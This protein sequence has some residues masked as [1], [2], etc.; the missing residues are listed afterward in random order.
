MPNGLFCHGDPCPGD[1]RAPCQAQ[2]APPTVPH[3]HSPPWTWGPASASCDVLQV[4]GLS[5]TTFIIWS[6]LRELVTCILES[7]HFSF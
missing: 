6:L 4:R 2:P 1:S 3:S 7:A 5:Q